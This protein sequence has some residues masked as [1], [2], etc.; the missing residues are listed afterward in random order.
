MCEAPGIILALQLTASLNID[1]SLM[2]DRTV[3]AFLG[4][5]HT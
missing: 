4:G 1:R 2:S 3:V 5:L